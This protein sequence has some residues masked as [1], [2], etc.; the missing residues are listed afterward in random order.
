DL[1]AGIRELVSDRIDVSG[2]GTLPWDAAV[3]RW[4]R[5]YREAFARH[6]P[7]IALL[8]VRPIAGA[9]RTNRMYDDVCGGLVAAGWPEHEVLTVIVALESFILGAA[10]DHSAPD[11]MLDIGDDES[12]PNFRAAYRARS[13]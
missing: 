6:P 3:D 4:A 9:T 5:S 11:D 13:A 8:A 2:F 7:T 1:I 12:A 10:L